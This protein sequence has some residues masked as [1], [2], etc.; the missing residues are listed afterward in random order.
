MSN[1]TESATDATL[2]TPAI[3]VTVREGIDYI[4]LKQTA[5]GAYEHVINVNATS[6]QAALR[7][8]TLDEGTYIA[9]PARSFRPIRLIVEKTERIKFEPST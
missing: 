1:Q 6:V 9:T 8:Y 5:P 2:D 7:G 4:I 3:P